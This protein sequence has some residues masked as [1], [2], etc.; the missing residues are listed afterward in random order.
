[1]SNGTQAQQAAG[2]FHW[3][4]IKV[5]GLI[6]LTLGL[7]LIPMA[8]TVDAVLR[9]RL[10]RQALYS[11]QQQD[12][13]WLQ[14]LRNDLNTAECGIQS[15]ARL[16][17]CAAT[18]SE[19][20]DDEASFSTL[21]QR[22][23][24]GLWRSRRERFL[25]ARDA[26]LWA[27][28]A[29]VDTPEDRSFFLR[30]KRLMEIYGRGP[31]SHLVANTWAL[32]AENGE[33]V[34]WPEEPEFIYKVTPEQDYRPTEWFQLVTPENNPLGDTRWTSTSFDPVSQVW[35]ISV[36]APFQRNGQWGGSAGH[37]LMIKGLFQHLGAETHR[38][39][40]EIFVLD[41]NQHVLIASQHQ[42]EIEG[43]DGQLRVDELNDHHLAGLLKEILRQSDAG[44]QRL[45]VLLETQD[46]LVTALPLEHPE[47]LT[48]HTLP[49]HVARA[50]AAGPLR[51]L[52]WGMAISMITLL[53]ACAFVISRDTLR[54][55]S[56][57]AELR[58]SHADLEKYES[59]I[60]R[61]PA[62]V[63]LWRAEAG[64]PVEFV[65]ENVAQFGYE[66]TDLMA[67]RLSWV[68]TLNPED[69]PGLEAEVERQREQGQ[70]EFNL[71]FRVRTATGEM[72]WVENRMLLILDARGHLTHVQGIMLDITERRRM[73]ETLRAEQQRH[74]I[75]FNHSG[76]GIAYYNRDGRLQMMNE[77]A[78]RTL[79]RDLDYLK[80]RQPEEFLPLETATTAR[81]RLEESLR[82]GI[83]NTYEDEVEL[84][85]GKR[86]FISTF[87][88]IRDSGGHA[89]G[90]QVVSQDITDRKQVEAELTQSEARY[91]TIVE[92]AQ[93]GV[94]TVDA[95][96]RTTFVNR[97]MAEMLGYTTAEMMGQP[98]FTFVDKEGAQEAQH[99]FERRRKGISETHEF[100][101]KHKDGADLW[102]M[103]STNPSY[104]ERGNFAGSL[105]LV[106]NITE[107]RGY[108][109]GKQKLEQQIRQ[110]Q[111]MESLGIMAAGIAHDFNNLLQAI[112]GHAELAL[113]DAPAESPQRESLREIQKAAQRA[114]VISTQM[115]SYVG[116][117]SHQRVALHLDQIVKDLQPTFAQLTENRAVFMLDC[118]PDL[119]PLLADEAELKH[120]LIQLITNAVEAQGAQPGHINLRANYRPWRPAE[121]KE[122]FGAP[123]IVEGSYLTLTVSD[124]GCGI[125]RAAMNHLFEPFFSTKFPGRGLGLMNVLG[126][127]RGHGGGIKVESMPGH[128][129]TFTLLLIEA[130]LSPVVPEVAMPWGWRGNG[131][132][133]LVD[134]EVM[135]L[136]VGRRMLIEL[137]FN[138]ITAGDGQEAIQVYRAQQAVIRCVVLDLIMPNLNGIET[139]AALR[140]INPELPVII[141]TAY[142]AARAGEL[143]K[144]LSYQGL[145]HKPYQSA[146]LAR[147]LQSL[148][149]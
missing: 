22:D 57:E 121:L 127:V 48:V 107:Q 38:D 139:L 64:W 25:P 45:P 72:R 5:A 10:M 14:L 50:L 85:G 103:I 124:T 24:D 120:I 34:F 116:Q 148:L 12:Q 62:V 26:G 90:V 91:R 2:S 8:W 102:T 17:S 15:F 78:C 28:E 63:F 80:G 30:T 41:R 126:F 23:P 87:T 56:A 122:L 53:S 68:S 95:E 146:A 114:G 81:Q 145:V 106:T 33:V 143:L 108:E 99:Y 66:A 16:L 132:I 110:A 59:F 129:S 79:H 77:T 39:G 82:D 76:V 118:E 86:W 21:M 100:R 46:E 42:E 142:P 98:L 44:N 94:W 128:G 51:W 32:A 74:Q 52:R 61:S 75:L 31:A 18:Q 125:D 131:T 1:M 58:L 35:M 130:P 3:L 137:G 54:R 19:Q 104:D 11:L 37:D 65:S 117:G 71:E 141:S 140:E 47:W 67:G 136:T 29:A 27:P 49:R 113:L 96:A 9:E 115:L 92:T 135:I 101:F 111:R 6:L 147:L 119:P 89:L 83:V 40:G 60:N 144:G 97:R 7:I 88:C 149:G 112:Q 138:V 4:T 105:A 70:R 43:A 84:P 13:A 93:E 109:T 133:L 123:E 20:A 134:D 36:V 73:E 55:L 69:L